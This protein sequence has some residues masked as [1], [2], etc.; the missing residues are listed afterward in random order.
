MGSVVNIRVGYMCIAVTRIAMKGSMEHII[1]YTGRIPSSLYLCR[2]NKWCGAMP[3]YLCFQHSSSYHRPRC[4]IGNYTQIAKFLKPTWGPPGSCR[5]QMNPMLA[6]W[7]LLLGYG[8]PIT[9]FNPLANTFPGAALTLAIIRAPLLQL[10]NC[11]PCHSL[12]FILKWLIF[13]WQI[14]VYMTKVIICIACF[15]QSWVRMCPK[16]KAWQIMK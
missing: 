13:N 8:Q 14:H 3:G 6:P 5:P 2:A 10:V 16:K 9:F 7:T 4:G 1:R 11:A 15:T 12:G